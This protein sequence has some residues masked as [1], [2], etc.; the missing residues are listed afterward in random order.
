MTPDD[1]DDGWLSFISEMD[2]F[3][4]GLNTD[5]CDCGALHTDFPENHYKWCTAFGLPKPVRAK[6]AK[7]NVS[8]TNRRGTVSKNSKVYRRK[9]TTK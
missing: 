3:I 1:Q 2:G 4:K 8:N 6:E 5:Q 7:Q 9:P